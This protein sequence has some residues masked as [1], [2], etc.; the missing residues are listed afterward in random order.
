MD[1]T[2]SSNTDEQQKEPLT[3]TTASDGE[4]PRKMREWRSWKVEPVYTI[5]MTI[6]GT[7]I[8]V[9]IVVLA[10]L[11]QR[12]N[13]FA[14]IL[15]RYHTVSGSM[16]DTYVFDTGLLWTSL[17]SL[18]ITLYNLAWSTMV[19][20]AIDRQPFIDLS[21][22][23][24][25]VASRSIALDYRTELPIWNCVVAL[26]NRHF[27]ISGLM[28]TTL[29]MSL[30]AA[31]AAHLFVLKSIVSNDTTML[32]TTTAF[33]SSA[34]TASTDMRRI[35]DLVVATRIYGASPPPWNN[36]EYAFP[37]IS[38]PSSSKSLSLN[39]SI[40]A[41]AAYL[42]CTTLDSSKYT[43][44]LEDTTDPAFSK[45]AITGDDRGCS[46]SPSVVVQARTSTYLRTFTELGCASDVGS[47]RFGLI[48]GTYSASSPTLLRNFSVISCIPQYWT[49]PGQLELITL[50][51]KQIPFVG[52]FTRN[53]TGATQLGSDDAGMGAL[54]ESGLDID[55]AID[56]TNAV[57]TTEFGRILLQEAQ[58]R[59][60]TPMDAGILQGAISEVFTSAFAMLGSTLMF[61]SI[62]A[63]SAPVV[64]VE[65]GK[66]LQRLFIY[67]PV[68]GLLCVAIGSSV[69]CTIAVLLYSSTHASILREEPSGLLSYADILLNSNISNLVDQVRA[70]PKYDGRIVQRA[71]KYFKFDKVDC[72]TTGTGEDRKISVGD[73]EPKQDEERSS[74]GR[75]RVRVYDV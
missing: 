13:G 59:S 4:A 51:G 67:L 19:T 3:T 50:P 53:A 63:G 30:M 75:R 27:L 66:T 8:V 29:I 12:N 31:A 34:L 17:P 15:T 73:M 1:P 23:K 71:R 60:A 21:V 6:I 56:A 45:L 7:L 43:A 5:F 10:V 14:T 18:I 64:S 24:K 20:A 68:A 44:T 28:A 36:G 47:R 35:L 42:I 58:S 62:D 48:S 26:K 38:L 72:S 70:H 32:A 74:A 9:L 52:S 40:D 57:S 16:F 65:V 55:L 69:L 37:T 25:V 46:I 2:I 61:T 49:I 39:A 22:K 33:N 11:S 41:H 54:F